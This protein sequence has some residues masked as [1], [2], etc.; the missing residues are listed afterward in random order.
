MNANEF[1]SIMHSDQKLWDLAETIAEG[2]NSITKAIEIPFGIGRREV[3]LEGIGDAKRT[4]D[5]LR[6]VR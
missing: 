6:S 3:T 4:T 5:S 1:R 2:P